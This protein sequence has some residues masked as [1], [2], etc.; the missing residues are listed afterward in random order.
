MQR[1]TRSTSNKER[2]AKR[3]A[4]STHPSTKEVQT[5]R[6]RSVSHLER[7][8]YACAQL[9]REY[10]TKHEGSHSHYSREC[11]AQVWLSNIS[12]PFASIDLMEH[13]E[14]VDLLCNL[15][16][17][18]N[19]T[20]SHD[21]ICSAFYRV[22]DRSRINLHAIVNDMKSTFDAFAAKVVDKAKLNE[23]F[24]L[25]PD[26]VDHCRMDYKM[27]VGSSFEIDAITPLC[28]DPD[29][30]IPARLTTEFTFRTLVHMV[31]K[32]LSVPMLQGMI[33]V[34]GRPVEIW[35]PS[36]SKDYGT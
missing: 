33:V 32:Y 23:T 1:I 14:F 31:L 18:K 12:E 35:K 16:D 4:T 22:H 2:G 10:C 25:T 9:L 7:I 19:V 29:F 30:T 8:Q 28:D 5:K 36:L 20:L 24:R 17:Q 11:M 21:E 13:P 15:E 27:K 34:Q 3:K 6:I 26:I